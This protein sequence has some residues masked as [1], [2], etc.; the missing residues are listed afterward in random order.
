MQGQSRAQTR[1]RQRLKRVLDF[2]PHRLA[3]TAPVVTEFKLVP[4]FITSSDITVT[5][6]S[7]EPGQ[8]QS[9]KKNPQRTTGSLTTKFQRQKKTRT[10]SLALPDTHSRQQQRGIRRSTH[11]IAIPSLPRLCCS[12][13]LPVVSAVPA[14]FDIPSTLDCNRPL[15]LS[16]LAAQL[17]QTPPSLLVMSPS[18]FRK[19]KT[20]GRFAGGK[21]RTKAREAWWIDGESNGRWK[22]GLLRMCP[23]KKERLENS[24]AGERHRGICDGCWNRRE[25]K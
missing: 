4:P 19:K 23:T 16:M 24:N 17:S 25:R 14:R 12:P 2:P 8:S 1:E 11:T 13:W 5:G 9:I 21:S 15:K 10:E 7:C 20:I 6:Q 18:I 22:C 3:H